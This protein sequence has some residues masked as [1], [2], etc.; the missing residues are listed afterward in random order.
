MLHW[1]VQVFVVVLASLLFDLLQKGLLRRLSGRLEG[2]RHLW[3]SAILSAARL[4]I[5]F[6]I[7]IVGI[8]FACQIIEQETGAAVFAALRPIRI[9]ALGGIVTWF[10][11]RLV[12]KLQRGLIAK[13][14]KQGKKIDLTTADALGK[15]VRIA[16]VVTAALAT[17]QTL[18]VSISGLLAMGGIGGL[19]IG[20]AAQDLL[21]NFFGAFMLYWDRPFKVG[22]WIA[23][24]DREIEGTVEQIGWRLTC[25]RTFEKRPLYVPNSVFTKITVINPS[26]M[27]HRRIHE[28][29]GVRYDDAAVVPAILKDVR[30]MLLQHDEIDETQ[31]LMVNL[32]SFGPSSLDFFIYTFTKTTVWTK[33]HTVKEDVLLQICNIIAKHGAEVA[34]PTSTLHVP[35][36]VH[37]KR[38]VKEALDGVMHQESE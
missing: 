24:P 8:A 4:P 22:D 9:L 27:T 14:T 1:I 32:N 29:I 36:T 5:R 11:I 3:Y 15:V 2:S 33:F 13:Y 25:I 26:R 6:F 31:T 35:G 23:S 34:F 28:T 16:I 17:L 10:V 21:S 38:D 30:E 7:W 20:F 12:N 19:A 18:G 37:I